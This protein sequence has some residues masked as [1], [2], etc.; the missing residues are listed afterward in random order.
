[1]SAAFWGEGRRPDHCF[2]VLGRHDRTK[3]R[4]PQGIVGAGDP[5]RAQS[6]GCGRRAPAGAGEWNATTRWRTLRSWRGIRV[7]RS[8]AL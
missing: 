1:M 8:G 3:A 4:W 7:R 6:H 5:G 2:A